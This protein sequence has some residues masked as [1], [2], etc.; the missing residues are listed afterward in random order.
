VAVKLSHRQRQA[1][2]TRSAAAHAARRLFAADG[3]VATTIEGISKAAEIP[4]QTIYS[5]FGNKPAIL[6]EI[7]RLWIAESDVEELHRQALLVP[8]PEQRLRRAAHWTGRQLELGYEVIAIHIEAARANPR[9][10]EVWRRALSGREAAIRKL[11]QSMALN[12][13]PGLR[14][15]QAL[16]IYVTATLPEVYRTLVIERGWSQGRY[17]G[18]LGDLL[19]SQIIGAAP[20]A[21]IGRRDRPRSSRH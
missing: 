7:R 2:A 17:E 16:D 6:E 13:R 5:A 21:G 3:Y 10:A 20:I 9:V 12:L 18:W 11:L 8:D 4:V 15:A 1:Q 14:L 19:V